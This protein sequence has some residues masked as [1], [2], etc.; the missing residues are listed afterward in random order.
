MAYY[1]T[2]KRDPTTASTNW[3]YFQRPGNVNV[4]QSSA[5]QPYQSNNTLVNPLSIIFGGNRSGG[6]NMF[7]FQIPTCNCGM[8]YNGP[9]Y[10]IPNI[11]G[12][13]SYNGPQYNIPNIM[14]GMR[15]NGP[16]YNIPRINC[17]NYGSLFTIGAVQSGRIMNPGTLFSIGAVQSGGVINPGTLFSIGA[18]Q[19]GGMINPGNLFNIGPVQC[20]YGYC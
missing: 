8:S 10:N 18:V 7:D 15:Y 3:H 4:R 13:M 19:S 1:L 9:H 6:N 5:I 16:T 17:G 20:G 2:A 14:G 12:G 11:M